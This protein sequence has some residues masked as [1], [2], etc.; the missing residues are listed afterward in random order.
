MIE[1]NTNINDIKNLKLVLHEQFYTENILG[2]ICQRL[3][4]WIDIFNIEYNVETRSITLKIKK[5]SMKKA[6]N[7]FEHTAMYYYEI[8]NGVLFEV[9]NSNK[10]IIQQC[11]NAHQAVFGDLSGNEISIISCN[12]SICTLYNVI[13]Q[14]D[15]VI[16]IMF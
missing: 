11:L 13:A 8:I 14:A 2:A 15:N 10:N 16:T 6:D 4:Q 12:A 3:G 9:Y 5:T 7:N 1:L